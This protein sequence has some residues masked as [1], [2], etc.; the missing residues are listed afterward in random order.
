MRQIWLSAN[1]MACSAGRRFSART[2]ISVSALSSSQRCRR[3]CSPSKLSSGTTEMRLASRRLG[4]KQT[5]WGGVRDG[6]SSA[7]STRSVAQRELWCRGGMDRWPGDGAGGAQEVSAR[8]PACA[9]KLLAATGGPFLMATR[10][11][12]WIKVRRMA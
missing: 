6:S 4:G 3:D 9:P 10:R 2:G 1:V 11:C 7:R 12:W 8:G 5:G